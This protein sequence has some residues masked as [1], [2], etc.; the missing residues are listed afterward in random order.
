M[1]YDI[2]LLFIVNRSNYPLMKLSG[3][4]STLEG[5]FVLVEDLPELVGP[6]SRDP[7]RN[8]GLLGGQRSMK[9]RMSRWLI[10]AIRAL[11]A[12]CLS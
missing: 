8:R 11:I 7:A 3:E 10:S 4:N 12:R 6:N 2:L 5:G 1:T 9:Y